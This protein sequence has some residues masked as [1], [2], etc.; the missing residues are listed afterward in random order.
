MHSAES[1]IFRP[2]HGII[3]N[4]SV[5]HSSMDPAVRRGLAAE[6]ALQSIAL[7]GGGIEQ[8]FIPIL[9]EYVDGRVDAHE[10]VRRVRQQYGL[11]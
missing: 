6:M 2:F 1:L 3:E 9:M 4:M 8:R 11:G 5:S 10:V 7:E